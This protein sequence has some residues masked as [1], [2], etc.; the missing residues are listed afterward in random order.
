MSVSRRSF[1]QKIG[2]ASA[3]LG[4]GLKPNWLQALHYSGELDRVSH[5][6]P[7]QVAEDETFW[8]WV[9]HS[10]TLNY[11]I[12]NLNNGGVSP[13]PKMVQDAVNQYYQTSNLGPTYFMWRIL[14]QGREPLRKELAALAECDPEELAVNR[15]ASEA[16]ETI[17]FGL[18]LKKGDEVILTRYDYPNMLNAWK[19]RAKREGIVLKYASINPMLDTD[20]DVI[21]AFKKQITSKTRVLHIT[22]MI[23]W[24]GRVLPAAELANLAHDNK[25]LA[26]CDAAHSFAHLCYGISDLGCDFLGTSLHKWLCAPFGT[27]LLYVKKEHIANLWPL[28]SP[29]DPESADIRKFEALGTRNFAIEQGIRDAIEFHRTLGAERKFL[30]LQYLKNYWVNKVAGHP[31]IVL[32]TPLTANSGALFHVGIKGKKGIEIEQTL[33][34][35]YK[36]HCVAI[37]YEEL[38]GVRITPHVYTSL[39][40]L[41]LLVEGLLGMANER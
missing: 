4:M 27:G 25:A 34:N 19:Q 14:D 5:L 6:S 28:L 3:I 24:N 7:M 31:N 41:D 16:L 17:I 38:M 37:D 20:E 15:N 13:Q 29:E 35:K 11:D 40:D 39:R 10:F 1:L 23:N 22:H 33:F 12:I 36:I 8:R 21:S 26:V 18:N 9:R 2:G 30:R 32:N